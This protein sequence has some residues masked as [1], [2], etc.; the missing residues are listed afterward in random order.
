MSYPI[1][2]KDGGDCPST[3]PVRIPGVFFEHTFN[4]GDFPHGDGTNNFVWSMGDNTGYGHHGDFLSGWDEKVMAAAIADP[5]CSNDNP[6]M[7]FGNNVKSCPPLAQ[8]VKDGSE[9][10]CTG[11]TNPVPLTENLGANRPL[12]RM[13]GCFDYNGPIANCDKTPAGSDNAGTYFIKSSN[14]KFLSAKKDSVVYANNTGT[15]K[16]YSEVWAFGYAP[17]NQVTIQNQDSFGVVS[18]RDN[19]QLVGQNRA[20][21]WEYWIKE[22]VSGNQVAFKSLRTSQ[23]LTQEADGT[24]SFK[25]ANIS[26]A[27]TF[28]L[29]PNDG[30][31]VPADDG[32]SVIAAQSPVLAGSSGA[33]K[34]ATGLVVVAFLALFF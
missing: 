5:L 26:S 10:K 32:F 15:L 21:T 8:Y 18:A 27:Q 6:D 34:I 25:A 7:A 22:T 3:H 23:Y 1:Q 14:G 2:R 24:L 16:S 12:S 30:G 28:E 19:A 29:V 17:D 4:V 20:S 11:L 13:P 31:Y 33:A 9:A